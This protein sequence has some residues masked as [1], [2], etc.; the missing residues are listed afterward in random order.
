L[1]AYVFVSSATALTAVSGAPSRPAVRPNKKPET[2]SPASTTVAPIRF[3]QDGEE[4]HEV[5]RNAQKGDTLVCIKI[6]ASWCRSCKAVGPKFGRLSNE[7]GADVEF[8]SLMFDDNKQLCKKLGVKV[9]PVMVIVPGV[10]ARGD[11]ELFACGPSKV[12]KLRRMLETRIEEMREPP[13]PAPELEATRDV[14][15][16]VEELWQMW[17][18]G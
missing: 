15:N 5:V 1:L 14:E 7:L 3:I 16:T 2:S 11:V 6:F 4:Y 13:P 10:P 8:H 17:E 9:L 18:A 12:P